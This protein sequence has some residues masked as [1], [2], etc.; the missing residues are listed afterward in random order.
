MRKPLTRQSAAMGSAAAVIAAVLLPIT[1]ASGQEHVTMAASTEEPTAGSSVIVVSSLSDAGPGSLRRAIKAANANPDH[2]AISFSV[3]GVIKL[4]SDLPTVINPVLIDGTTSPGYMS[5]GPPAVQLNHRAAK[6]LSLRS[7]AKRSEILALSIVGAQGH[8]VRVH[9]NRVTIDKSYI[10]LT[11][12]GRTK[13]NGGAGVYLAPGTAKNQ[14][15][16]NA[17]GVPGVVGNVISG[18][19]DSG[20]LLA[21]SSQNTLAANRIGT[22]PDGLAKIPNRGHG[23]ALTK[24]SKRNVIG[25]TADSDPNSGTVNNPTGSKG[26]VA[27]TFVV[28]ALGNLISGNRH[29]GVQISSGSTKNVLSGNFVGTT[30][31][32][33]AALGNR[34]SGVRIRKADGNKLI[35]CT[36]TDNPFVYYNVLSGNGRHGL[37]VT[38][39]DDVLVQANFFG[40]GANNTNVVANGRNGILVDKDSQDTQVGGVIPLGNVAAG[41]GHNGIEVKDTAQGFVTFNTFGG[42][43][44][45]KGAAPNQRNGLLITTTGGDTSVRT[46]VFSGNRGNGIKLAKRARDVT[47]DP[48][49]V[50]ATTNAK[51]PLPNGGHGLLIADHAHHNVIGGDRTSVIPQNTFS[52]NGGFGIAILNKAHHNRVFA[53][54]VGTNVFGEAALPNQRGGVL[55]SNQAYKN[56]IGK[57]QLDPANI[58]S[59][60]AGNGVTMRK[61]TVKNR[62]IN[63]YVGVDRLGGP[64]PNTGMAVVNQNQ[65]NAVRGVTTN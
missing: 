10:G 62:L 8:G 35:G 44:A 5:G 28:P 7:G 43:L 2:S 58:I 19:R 39:A 26:T 57:G 14:V 51:N 11:R 64:L 24:R 34:R 42:L 52:A 63:S 9:A 65:S 30:A 40:I 23:I 38:G 54:F 36:L 56:R 22:S 1:M 29:N 13:A 46:N 4:R 48:N 12:S 3:T 33:N 41:N 16:F 50:G 32:G 21:G 59:G 18:N 37:H 20:V 31:D 17:G 49:I 53:T 15:G 55:I 60:N 27:P 6:G 45:F 47:I 61:R 25:G